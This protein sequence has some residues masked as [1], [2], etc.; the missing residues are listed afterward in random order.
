MRVRN[1]FL[2]FVVRHKM[3]DEH[4]RIDK[5][6]L[7]HPL[8][9]RFRAAAAAAARI[10]AKAGKRCQGKRFLEPFPPASCVLGSV[11]EVQNG[12]SD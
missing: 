12:Y 5:P 1:H 8:P 4:I 11:V 10:R 2:G 3:P 7:G 6:S 9:S